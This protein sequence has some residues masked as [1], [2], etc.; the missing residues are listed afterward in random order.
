MRRRCSGCVCPSRRV[1][2]CTSLRTTHLTQHPCCQHNATLHAGPTCSTHR[3]C[4]SCGVP[5][6]GVA[7]RM[8]CL[9]T[10]T[11]PH[12]HRWAANA[13][14]AVVCSPLHTWGQQTR[15]MLA[16]AASTRWR[17]WCRTC[18]ASSTCCR[19]TRA[20]VRP[21]VWLPGLV[22]STRMLWLLGLVLAQHAVAGAGT[23]ARLVGS[24]PGP[25]LACAALK[26]TVV[27]RVCVCVSPV[28]P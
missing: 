7:P 20:G 2:A 18:L 9:A 28:R 5:G 21:V 27:L 6:G 26:H 22:C 19:S 11:R 8:V 14:R 3:R 25:Q 16:A 24:R 1:C 10:G 17:A 13:L 23:Q 4:V 12:V 15:R